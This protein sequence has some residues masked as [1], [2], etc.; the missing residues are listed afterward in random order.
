MSFKKEIGPSSP[1][2]DPTTLAADC[3]AI[4]M[5]L[6]AARAK[7]SPNIE[8]TLLFASAEAVERDA[9]LVA[10]LILW[11]RIH[12]PWVNADRL[13]RLV[14]GHESARVR[15]LWAGLARWHKADPRF[16]RLARVHKGPRITLGG[17]G[18][19]DPRFRKGPVRLAA[20]LTRERAADVLSPAALARRHPAYRWRLIIGPGYRADMW[21]A[22]EADPDL[23]AAD[24]AR[25]AYGSFATAWHVKRDFALATPR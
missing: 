2:P 15:A 8:D 11:F 7:R 20:A 10:P 22:L 3:A 16:A 24:L 13:T 4:G 19:E 21:A 23:S 1:P 18:V 9:R 14:G 5:R 6:G 12:H 17:D 25:H